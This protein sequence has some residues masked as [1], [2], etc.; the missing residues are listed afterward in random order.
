MRARIEGWG[1]R[2]G[3]VAR[4]V[5]GAVGR[6]IGALGAVRRFVVSAQIRS[7]ML[8]RARYGTKQFQGEAYSEEDRYPELFAECARRLEGVAAPRILS[9]GCATGEEVF[10]LA[11][12]VPQAEIVGVDINPW[13]LQQCAARNTSERVRFVHR[14]GAEFGGLAQV[15]AAK[16][17]AVFAMA[18]FQRTEHRTEG[19]TPEQTGFTFAEFEREV[20]M[21]DGMLRVDGMLFVD[22]CDFRF[23]ETGVAG[24]YVAME[25]AGN[26]VRR[27]RA[28]FDGD[29]RRVAEEYEAV[30]GWEK[31][32]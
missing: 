27:V 19:A 16:F 26:T 7:Q 21:L 15:D 20:E 31:R 1:A 11:R 8:A 9:F 25:F 13:C 29:N 24:R 14:L 12:Y 30:R 28:L 3:G 5:C 22:E 17:D 6:G 10:S 2:R 23:A 4:V 18:V 32:G